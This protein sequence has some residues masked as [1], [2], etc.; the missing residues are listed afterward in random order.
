[1]IELEIWWISVQYN[2][3]YDTYLDA[4]FY[5]YTCPL[6]FDLKL[7]EKETRTSSYPGVSAV[8]RC[9]VHLLV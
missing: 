5:I 3:P 7:K 4:Y 9:Q 8:T 2:I 1:M 6:E